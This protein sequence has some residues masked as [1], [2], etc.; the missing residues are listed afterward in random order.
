MSP[1]S[2]G[3]ADAIDA[4]DEAESARPARLHPRRCVL[5]HGGLRRLYTESSR[6]RE[7]GVRGRL[8]MQ[9]IA[10]GDDA[11]DDR[12]EQLLYAGGREHVPA[13]GA[14]R[15]DRAMKPRGADGFHVADRALVRLH[16]LLANQSEHDLVLEIA[17][18]VDRLGAWRIVAT[19]VG[20]L[21][22]ARRQKR[23]NAVV[24]RLSIDV[25]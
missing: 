10:L 5:E 21:D 24:A 7:K 9:L 14:R 13:V 8:P 18:S 2:L 16:A 22:P 1:K 17:E 15:D 3:L 25:L 19:T 4:D 12:V 23:S 11:V 6:A 20:K